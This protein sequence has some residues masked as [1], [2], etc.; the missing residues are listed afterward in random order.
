MPIRTDK[1]T[2]PWASVQN[3]PTRAPVATGEPVVSFKIVGHR[4]VVTRF[5]SQFHNRIRAKGA[6]PNKDIGRSAPLVCQRGWTLRTSWTWVRSRDKG[7]E[8]QD[9]EDNY[10]KDQNLGPSHSGSRSRLSSEATLCIATICDSA[11]KAK[12][13]RR[14]APALHLRFS[15]G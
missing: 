11:L 3:G 4:D 2:T 10:D 5:V 9:E 8:C 7:N 14:R 13:G 1:V 6:D 12:T 15:L